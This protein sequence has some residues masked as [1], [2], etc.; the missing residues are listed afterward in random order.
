MATEIE[1]LISGQAQFL[2]DVRNILYRRSLIV[3]LSSECVESLS[4]AGEYPLLM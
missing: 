1:Y 2:E 4:R 3:G